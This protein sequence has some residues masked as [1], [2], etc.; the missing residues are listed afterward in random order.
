MAVMCS[1][2][3][4][5]LLRS[6]PGRG[7]DHALDGVQPAR[8]LELVARVVGIA[9][10]VRVCVFSA[11]VYPVQIAMPLVLSLSTHL[12]SRKVNRSCVIEPY[13]QPSV[14]RFPDAA[15]PVARTTNSNDALAPPQRR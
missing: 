8:R 6:C 3:C 10:D 12:P 2:I 1:N 7:L 15:I 4:C 14:T 9:F 13:P 11:A 5:N